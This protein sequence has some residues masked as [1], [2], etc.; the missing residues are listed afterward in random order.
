MK[1]KVLLVLL[2]AG[3][4]VPFAQAQDE[5]VTITAWGH[6]HLPRVE[7]D[8]EMIAAFM[9]ANPHITVEY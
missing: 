3:L 8:Q 6:N 2:I 9:E 5:P 1:V 7:L 4:L